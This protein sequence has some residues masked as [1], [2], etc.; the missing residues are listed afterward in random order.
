MHVC[1]NRAFFADLQEC[2]GKVLVQL[3][4]VIPY[5]SDVYCHCWYAIF[6]HDGSD[7][8]LCKAFWYVFGFGWEC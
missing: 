2:Y 1:K 8:M 5:T 6:E 4:S 7:L 3:G